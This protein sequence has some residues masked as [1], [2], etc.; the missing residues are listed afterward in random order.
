VGGLGTQAVSARPNA[1]VVSVLS[2]QPPHKVSCLVTL[3]IGY[4]GSGRS[5]AGGLGSRTLGGTAGIVSTGFRRL[6]NGASPTLLCALSP[7]S[8]S[9]GSVIEA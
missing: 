6:W 2:Q 7:P 9:A 4:V 1:F 5:G 3:E 8:T